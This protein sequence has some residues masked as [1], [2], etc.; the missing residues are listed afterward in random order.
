MNDFTLAFMDFSKWYSWVQILA[1]TLT[2]IVGAHTLYRKIVKP[3]VV[4]PMRALADI[5]TLASE[6]KPGPDGKTFKQTLNGI[7]EKVTGFH[8]R[9][10]GMEARSVRNE[11]R[12][13]VMIQGQ[14]GALFETCEC[15]EFV[16][17]NRALCQLAN[18]T[19]GELLGWNWLQAVCEDDRLG[20]AAEWNDC[21]AKGRAFNYTFSFIRN[22]SPVK[23]ECNAHPMQGADKVTGW[24]GSIK[25]VV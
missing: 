16:L 7:D 24:L 25:E 21:V 9:L 18:R 19:E 12:L 14:G 20:V 11:E 15:G 23:V 17:V 1:V 2:A 10:D 3:Y 8:R 5:A 13:R 4:A 22:G 6:L